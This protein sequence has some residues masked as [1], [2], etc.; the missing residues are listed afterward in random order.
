MVTVAN[1]LR[2]TNMRQSNLLW[3]NAGSVALYPLNRECISRM[4]RTYLDWLTLHKTAVKKPRKRRQTVPLPPLR[5]SCV[6]HG[7]GR[8]FRARPASDRVVTEPGP[9]PTAI[10][11]FISEPEPMS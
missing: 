1:E 5:G 4:C 9:S 10:Q 3:S 6:E 7:S 2:Q 8:L 11:I